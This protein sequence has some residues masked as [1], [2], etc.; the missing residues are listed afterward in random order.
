MQG[1][2]PVIAIVDDDET[3]RRALKRLVQSLSFRT[4]DFESGEAFLESIEM[5]APNCALVDLHMP[6]LDGLQVLIAM[7]MRSLA[8]PTIVI[9]ANAQPE[10]RERC[11]G[12]GAAA[13][14]QKPLDRDVVLSTIRAAMAE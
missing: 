3:V 14:L 1:S 12:A 4:T 7:R 5:H 10:M 8:I 9:T 13:Y 2:D 6:G 11:M